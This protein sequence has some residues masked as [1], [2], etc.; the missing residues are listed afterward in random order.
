M[1]GCSIREWGEGVITE[2]LEFFL[3]KFL[4]FGAFAL[5]AERSFLSVCL[6]AAVSEPSEL[7]PKPAGTEEKS[8]LRG[9]EESLFGGT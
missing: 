9:W 4:A 5:A 6:A 7:L 1:P 8:D 2:L 3:C